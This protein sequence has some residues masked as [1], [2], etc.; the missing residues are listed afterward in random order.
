MFSRPKPFTLAGALFVALATVSLMAQTNSSSAQIWHF[1]SLQTIDGHA[2]EVVG[3]PKL[4]DTP[5]GKAVHFNGSTDVIYLPVHP[6]AG[7]TTFTWEVI[8]RPDGGHEEQRFFHLQ[9]SANGVDGDSRMLFEIR[10]IGDQWCLDGFVKSGENGLTLIDRAKLF[11]IGRWYRVTLVYDGR[12]LHA[13][14]DNALQGEGPLPFV[15]QTSGR[16][17]VGMRINKISPFHGAVLEA[18]MTPKAL[19]PAEFLALPAGLN[20]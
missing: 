10:V 4:I 15:P 16:T 8:F 14:V 6:L 3:A 13:Y 2:V 1:D 20:K 9:E 12:D 11:P 17:S 19:A 5:A 7:A 18:R